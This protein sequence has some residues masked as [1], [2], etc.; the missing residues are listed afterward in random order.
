MKGAGRGSPRRFPDE[1]EFRGRQLRRGSPK[2]ELST[3]ERKRVYRAEGDALAA[4]LLMIPSDRIGLHA[5]R[6]P[7]CGMFHLGHK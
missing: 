4:R 6:C 3:C 7:R 1:V 2:D 5:Y